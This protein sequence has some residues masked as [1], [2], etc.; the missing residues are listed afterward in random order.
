MA[1]YA[2]L[3]QGDLD[4]FRR[5]NTEYVSKSAVKARVLGSESMEQF[6]Q[7]KENDLLNSEN[8]S[9]EGSKDHQLPL[10]SDEA[11]HKR[12]A[13]KRGDRL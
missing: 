1:E 5:L 4:N 3:R 7:F 9:L 13:Q 8:L 2:S 11:Y 6:E 12:I 10:E